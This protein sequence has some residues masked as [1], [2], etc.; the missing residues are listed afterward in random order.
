VLCD[1]RTLTSRLVTEHTPSLLSPAP[2]VRHFCSPFCWTPFTPLKVISGLRTLQNPTQGFLI[3]KTLQFT[4][5]V[6]GMTSV[7]PRRE[8]G[9]SLQAAGDIYIY[10]LNQGSISGA[11]HIYPAS[12]LSI[13]TAECLILLATIT[14]SS[15]FDS[16]MVFI[17]AKSRFIP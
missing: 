10:V 3:L 5:P 11:S 17:M 4:H 16:N 2:C 7:S 8:D 13:K 12:S 9:Y 15:A 6:N 1:L 14:F